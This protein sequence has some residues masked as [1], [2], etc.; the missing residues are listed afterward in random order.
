ME[1]SFKSDRNFSFVNILWI[2][3]DQH[4]ADCLGYMG[5]PTAQTPHLD[6]LA[7]ISLI[8]DGVGLLVKALEGSGQMDDTLI[9]FAADHGEFLGNHGLLR[10]TSIHY[11]ETLRVPLFLKMPGRQLAARREKGLVELTDIFPTLLGLLGVSSPPGV[12]GQDWSAAIRKGERIGRPD[13]YADMF[14]ITPQRFGRLSGPYMAVQTLRTEQ[15]KLNLYPTAGQRYGQLFNLADDPDE[16]RNL[17]GD[18]A[19][20]P[21]R[22]ELLWRMASRSHANL[23]PLPPYLT[24]Y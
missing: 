19:H 4:R 7:S 18:G 16:S 15:W 10:K 13:I 9:L 20:R 11:D 5:H 22:E 23:D 1:C 12:Q 14:D 21:V 8:D 24:Q 17:Y 6:R 3:T 2:M